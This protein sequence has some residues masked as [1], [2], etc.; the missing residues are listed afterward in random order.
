MIRSA[1]RSSSD[2]WGECVESTSYRGQV[3]CSQS[4]HK[5]PIQAVKS[6]ELILLRVSLTSA[7]GVASLEQQNPLNQLQRPEGGIQPSL[8]EPGASISWPMAMA[9]EMARR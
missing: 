1:F 5:G 8:P 4:Q 9:L 3:R 7:E 2:L 6:A